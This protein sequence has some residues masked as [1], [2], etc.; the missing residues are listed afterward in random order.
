MC[1]YILD[2]EKE[3][4]DFK[5]ENESLIQRI[6]FLESNTMDNQKDDN[7][8]TRLESKNEH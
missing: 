5:Q 3:L 1:L 7:F 4:M 2:R 8:Q 6:T